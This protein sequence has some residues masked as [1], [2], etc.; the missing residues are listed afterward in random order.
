MGLFCEVTRALPSV[1]EHPLGYVVFAEG[2]LQEKVS[3][4]TVVSEHFGNGLRM[5]YL[6]PTEPSLWEILIDPTGMA[7]RIIYER[8]KGCLSQSEYDDFMSQIGQQL[9]NTDTTSVLDGTK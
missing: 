1:F 8:G 2:C 7:Y 5:P 9:S 4:V 3:C 6:Y